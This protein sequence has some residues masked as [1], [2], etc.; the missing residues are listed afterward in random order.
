[1]RK[2]NRDTIQ[3]PT[4]C[5]RAI[6]PYVVFP[7]DRMV[8]FLE[9]GEVTC[10]L[11]DG[12]LTTTTVL[13]GSRYAIGVGVTVITFDG[14]FNI[15]NCSGI[16]G[17]VYNGVPVKHNGKQV[18]TE[19]DKVELFN[20]LAK[21]S[22]RLSAP[23]T[24]VYADNVYS[25]IHAFDAK[26]VERG[27]MI[28]NPA[29]STITVSDTAWYKLR[30]GINFTARSSEELQVIAY[31]NDV[32]YSSNPI[33]IQAQGTDKPTEAFWE[34]DLQLNAG[35]VVDLRG[36]NGDIGNIDIEFTRTTFAVTKD[37]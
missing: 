9:P 31:V 4:T 26:V 24:E 20:I 11:G 1:M 18:T 35:D 28:A 23:I 10:R 7:Q 21:A 34:S 16:R 27:G 3:A 15:D 12:S 30:V 14:I 36:K 32:P 22:M 2:N 29:T 37:S 5:G 33:S 25:V 6:S 13:G 8:E 19:G 17:V